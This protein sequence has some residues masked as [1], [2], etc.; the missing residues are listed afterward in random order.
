MLHC[1]S[2]VR[3]QQRL[4]YSSIACKCKQR[5][6]CPVVHWLQ[7]FDVACSA[8]SNIPSV[9]SANSLVHCQALQRWQRQQARATAQCVAAALCALQSIVPASSHHMLSLQCGRMRRSCSQKLAVQCRSAPQCPGHLQAHIVRHAAN[10]PS[11]EAPR[12]GKASA[13]WDHPG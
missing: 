11:A 1:I 7:H 12:S 8:S 2:P 13:T 6:F 5:S 3:Q 10:T 9:N 4:I